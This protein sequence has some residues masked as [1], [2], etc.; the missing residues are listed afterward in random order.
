MPSGLRV[1]LPAKM[2]SSIFCERSDRDDCSPSTQRIAS[3]RFDLPEPFGPTTAVVPSMNSSVVASA[4]VL[5][6][7]TLSDFRRIELVWR[8]G[9]GRAGGSRVAATVVE[10]DHPAVVVRR[11]RL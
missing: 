10:R 6:P 3:T 11:R 4:K 9:V 2:T 8:S 7:K 5:K 1:L